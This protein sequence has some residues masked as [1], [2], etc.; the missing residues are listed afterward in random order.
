LDSGEFLANYYQPTSR[1]FQDAI[2]TG[3]SNGVPVPRK[4]DGPVGGS[5]SG[6]VS[7]FESPGSYG[8]GTL[9][10]R[11]LAAVRMCQPQTKL[12]VLVYVAE[13]VR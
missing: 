10:F 13:E 1:I 2:G 8:V 3:T 12:G 11:S 7:N 5:R 9:K 6:G 4:W